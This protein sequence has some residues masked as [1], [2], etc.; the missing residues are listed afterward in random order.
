MLACRRKAGQGV[1]R[2]AQAERRVQVR[3]RARRFVPRRKLT[4]QPLV[5]E[6]LRHESSRFR[7]EAEVLVTELARGALGEREDGPRGGK[8]G[9][10]A[11]ELLVTIQHAFVG[12]Q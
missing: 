7:Q 12:G 10:G 4:R 2:A 6:L 8:G 5:R 11:V 9:V 3:K 1:E